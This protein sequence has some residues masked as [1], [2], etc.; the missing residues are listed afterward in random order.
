MTMKKRL[1]IPALSIAVLLASGLTL[2]ACAP[3]NILNGLTPSGS[4][5]LAKDIAYGDLEAQKLDIYK[6]DAPKANAPIVMF[7]YGGSWNSGSKD[8]YKFMGQAFAAQGYTTVIPTYRVHPE[9]I[10]PEFINDTAKAVAYT[11]QQYDRPI[12]L[13]GHSA[14]A[15]IAAL[16]ALNPDYLAAQNIKS[17][18]VLSGW[19]S[20]AGPLDFKVLNEPFLSIFPE[21][22]RRADM[23]PI[24]FAA[25]PTPRVFIATGLDDTTVDP[26]QSRRMSAALREAGASVS[27]HYYEDVD[28]TGVMLRL[29]KVLR[30]DGKVHADMFKFI[31][32]LPRQAGCAP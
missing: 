29:S 15:H 21:D 10:F 2:A 20:L 5:T 12:V 3:V 18:D 19:A 9:V 31:D 17:C 26:N 27:D 7:I 11:A 1:L 13:V 16:I 30:R 8:I 24:H 4:Y 22:V 14:G 23:L 28:H 25:N 32:S 6:P